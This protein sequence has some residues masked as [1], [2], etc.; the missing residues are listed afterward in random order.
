MKQ[1]RTDSLSKAL[2]S[3]NKKIAEAIESGKLKTFL[4][5][6]GHYAYTFGDVGE[7]VVVNIVRVKYKDKVKP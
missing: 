7:R 5:V 1:N 4:E 6:Y 2:N 3:L